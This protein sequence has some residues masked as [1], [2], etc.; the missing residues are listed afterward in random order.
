MS[1]TV[2]FVCIL[3]QGSGVSTF[4]LLNCFWTLVHIISITGRRRQKATGRNLGSLVC[5]L[6]IYSEPL[7]KC[8]KSLNCNF[9][10]I[11]AF[12]M[13]GNMS[14]MLLE[15]NFLTF[16][17]YTFCLAFKNIPQLTMYMSAVKIKQEDGYL[18]D[19]GLTTST[20]ASWLGLC[21]L[22]RTQGR[23]SLA[24]EV[25]RH[26][27]SWR[28]LECHLSVALF[29]HVWQHQIFDVSLFSFF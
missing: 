13:S 26:V 1:A 8:L 6:N 27:H 29:T 28:P 25:W 22:P 5:A 12:K 4:L 16:L 7:W 15:K 21:V 24:A 11:C 2:T 9:F 18:C 23:C 19:K 17:S 20:S 14:T 3:F 10:W